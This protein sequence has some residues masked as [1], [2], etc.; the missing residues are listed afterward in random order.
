M[1]MDRDRHPANTERGYR[2]PDR[3][4]VIKG[5]EEVKEYI[6]EK[7]N[8][9]GSR[10]CRMLDKVD[11]AL[12]LLKE[13]ETTDTG[14]ERIFECEACGYGI[15]DIFLNSES[16]YSMVPKYCPNCGRS[17]KYV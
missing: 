1:P 10:K 8:D 14:K 13:Q 2:M 6:R 5:L 3:E 16:K 9:I 7:A 17:V 11:D 12:A 4:K 15:V